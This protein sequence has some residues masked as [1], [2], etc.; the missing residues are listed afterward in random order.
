[1]KKFLFIITTFLF[2]TI[3]NAQ[4]VVKSKFVDNTY[5]GVGTGVGAWL[6]PNCNGYENFGKSIHSIS[7]LRLGKYITPIFGMELEGEVG[8]ANRQTFVDHTN[9]GLNLLINMNNVIHGY[10]E[11]PDFVEAVPFIGLGWRHTYGYVTN[12][13]YSKAGVQVNFNVGKKEA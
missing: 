8:M 7:S 11:N 2:V 4:T 5:I 6:H 1:M 12:N 13:I 10:K 3:T 9:A